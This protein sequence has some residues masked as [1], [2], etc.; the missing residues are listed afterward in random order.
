MAD[1]DETLPVHG[2]GLIMETLDDIGGDHLFWMLQFS[3]LQV[4]FIRI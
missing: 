2:L 3:N 1:C 4:L